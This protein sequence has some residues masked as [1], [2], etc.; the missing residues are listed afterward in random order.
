MV[1]GGLGSESIAA[2][3][4]STNGL[5][6]AVMSP[7]EAA[8]R[9]L[10]VIQDGGLAVVPFDVSYAFLAGALEPLERIYK[11]KLRPS[12]K[13]CPM[14]VSWEQFLDIVHASPDGVRRVQ[15]VVDAG[16]PVG[17]LAKPDWDSE[18]ARPVPKNCRR[19]LE[20]DGKIALFMNMGGMSADILRAADDRGLRVFG[21]SA[22]LSGTGNSFSLDEVPT[23][24]LDSTDLRCDAGRC[25][26]ANAER[27][28][29]TIVELG[30]GEIVRTGILHDEIHKR[31][32]D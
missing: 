11:L 14:L 3:R 12:S 26:H 22:N 27:L 9:V 23:S 8:E 4:V 5:D 30:T 10:D 21:S 29:S 19:L 13:A 28:A 31:L 32:I 25:K 17:V 7:R 16:L 6:R 1:S 24:I 15:K 18:A 2:V 20:Q